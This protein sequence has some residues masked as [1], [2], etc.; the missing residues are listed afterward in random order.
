MPAVEG[1]VDPLG[2]IR[3]SRRSRVSIA[4]AVAELQ[5]AVEA[6]VVG[7]E[8]ELLVAQSPRPP[9]ASRRC[10]RRRSWTI[11]GA[12]SAQCRACSAVT[13]ASESSSRRDISIASALSRRRRSTSSEEYISTASR[14]SSRARSGLSVSGSAASASSSR[15]TPVTPRLEA[16]EQQ[17]AAE[18]DHVAE[19][20]AGEHLAVAEP[21]GELGCL[22]EAHPRRARVARAPAGV[23]ERAGAAR[24]AARARPRP[25]RAEQAERALVVHA[26]LLV[27][28]QARRPGHPPGRGSRSRPR[29]LRAAPPSAR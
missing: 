9:R 5:Q 26:G 21:A 24:S 18:P 28:E 14:A 13:S 3:R 7:E 27:G 15:P 17:E 4:G 11:S 23:A 6:A 12:P 19:R 25:A 22:L 1:L 20:G 10:S 8:G 2:Q 29:R 16:G